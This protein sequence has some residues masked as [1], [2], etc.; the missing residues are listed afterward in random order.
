MHCNCLTWDETF[1]I[2][3]KCIM[4]ISV[5]HWL[6]MKALLNRARLCSDRE[7]TFVS[8]QC[9]SL[10]HLSELFEHLIV[11]PETTLLSLQHAQQHCLLQ[12][13]LLLMSQGYKFRDSILLLE[14]F[15]VILVQVYLFFLLR[16]I[17]VFD[18]SDTVLFRLYSMRELTN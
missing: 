14:D 2:A 10:T 5:V 13:M 6:R 16:S 18:L 4:N 12:G 7:K 15:G 9:T 1:S 17:L 8:G 3:Q 11:N